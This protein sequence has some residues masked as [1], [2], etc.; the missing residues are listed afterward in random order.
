MALQS[1]MIEALL[2]DMDSVSEAQH[3]APST[4][5]PQKRAFDTSSAEHTDT[6]AW[7]FDVP[8]STNSGTSGSGTTGTMDTDMEDIFNLPLHTDELG[9]PSPPDIPG[10]LNGAEMDYASW[11]AQHFSSDFSHPSESENW[12]GN[13]FLESFMGYSG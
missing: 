3:T 12:T 2:G 6:G 10:E 4:T 1:D 5:G 9:R 8:S 7:S 13:G 11:F